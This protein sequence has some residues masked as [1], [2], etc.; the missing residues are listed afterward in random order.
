MARDLEAD[1]A[2]LREVLG[3]AQNRDIARAAAI[4]ER[5]VADGFEHPLLLNVLATRLEQGGRFEEAVAFLERAVSI[6]PGDVPARNALALALQRVGRPAE[7]LEHAEEILKAHPDL[8]FVHANKGD[9]LV[10]L[11]FLGRGQASH[12]RALELDPANLASVVSLAS[13]ASHLGKHE[14]ARGWAERVLAKMPN[15]PSAVISLA[16]AELA[17]KAL[18]KAEDL[19]RGLL[20]DARVAPADKARANGLLGDVLDAAGRYA[21]AYAAYSAC[22][23]AL[24]AAHPRFSGSGSLLGYSRSL[25]GAARASPI[26]N[27]T[28]GPS[29]PTHDARDHLFLLGFPRSG[30]TLLEVALDAHPQ[31]VS[32]EEHE[33]LT[34]GIVR[35]MGDPTTLEPLARAEEA[36]LERLRTAY[37]QRARAAGV[38]VAG[39]V[40]LDKHPM[41]TIKLP[42]IAKLFPRAKILFACR[43]PRD[44]VLSCFRRRF[45]MNPAMYQMLTL[46]SA[47]TFYDTVMAFAAEMR[48]VIGLDWRVVRFE[49]LVADFE[50]EMRAICEFAGLKWVAGMGDFAG[51]APSREH[52]TPST[53]QLARGLDGGGVGHWRHY[54]APLAPA[55]PLLDRWLRQFDYP[56]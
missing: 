18:D 32:L 54:A 31:V 42:L 41:N 20:T 45:K 14:E 8:S 13:I 39:K 21:E 51:R 44:V 52:A 1:Q 37:W 5:A 2:M 15:F 49:S 19:L 46:E 40:F 50:H 26:K 23:E 34:E 30:T 17:A 38:E 4:A 55:L 3:Y 35:F 36:E 11:G 9:A 22:N 43:D 47:A 6:A 29:P 10:A 25:L 33:L 28:A 16:A 48:P 12:L 24:R 7:A 27:W 56:A 53:A